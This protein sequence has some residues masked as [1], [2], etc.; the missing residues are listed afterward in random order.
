MRNFDIL[1]FDIGGVVVELA[2]AS[3][4]VELIG[5]DVETLNT[6][7]RASKA[8][9]EFE[10]GKS[11]ALEFA[12][13]L[14]AEFNFD[15]S[16]EQFLEDFKCFTKKP[17]RGALEFLKALSE[18][19]Y[20]AS[21]SNISDLQWDRLC[22]EYKVEKDFQKNF[23]S[24]KTGLMKPNKEA[25]LHVINELGCRP[26]RILFFDDSQRNVDM[27]LEVGMKAYKVKGINELKLK[28]EELGVLENVAV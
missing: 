15:I 25:Y 4:L 21:F 20:I 1:L 17:F 13:T 18:N 24:F 23:L 9:Y 8:V 5:E 26:E 2:G 16:T 3:K 10:T 14:I 6:K 28:L 19:F 12:D 7:P 22:K 27:G 11:T